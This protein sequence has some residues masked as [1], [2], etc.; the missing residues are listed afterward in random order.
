MQSC[1]GERQLGISITSISIGSSPEPV[2]ILDVPTVEQTH[3]MD[4]WHKAALM[5]SRYKDPAFVIPDD[6]RAVLTGRPCRSTGTA[7]C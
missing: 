5:I 2:Y 3:D 6:R 7:L 1:I 4:C